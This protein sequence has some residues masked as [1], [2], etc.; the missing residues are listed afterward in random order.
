MHQCITKIDGTTIDDDD[1]DLDLVMPMYNLIEYSSNYSKTTPSSWSYPIDEATK[2]NGDIANNHNLKS[3][4]Y[5]TK[6][7]RNTAADGANGIFRNAATVVPLKYLS[8]FWR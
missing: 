4:E 8:N 3:F 6:L 2:F 5:K 7:L 1:E